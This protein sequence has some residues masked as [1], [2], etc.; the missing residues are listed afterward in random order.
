[1]Q[2]PGVKGNRLAVARTARD[3]EPNL[4]WIDNS[5]WNTAAIECNGEKRCG[6]SLPRGQKLRASPGVRRVPGLYRLCNEMIGRLAD[7]RHDGHDPRTRSIPA[8]NLM[9]RI[10]EILL[11]LEYG[12]TQL[13]DNNFFLH[14]CYL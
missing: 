1:M 6:R 10:R 12:A 7:R 2:T 5:R 9:D 11:R 8:I 3:G 14:R 13:E 4:A